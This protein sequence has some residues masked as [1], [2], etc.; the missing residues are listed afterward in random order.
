VIKEVYSNPVYD[1]SSISLAGKN[2]NYELDYIN[3]EGE[4]G[5]V[6]PVSKFYKEVHNQLKSEFGDKDFLLFLLMTI[7]INFWLL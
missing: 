5:E 3:Y 2:R 7:I 4:R 1:V 6:I